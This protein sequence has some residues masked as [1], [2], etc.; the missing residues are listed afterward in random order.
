MA[1]VQAVPALD[2]FS[3][4]IKL[5]ENGS[6]VLNVSGELDLLTA[7]ALE[8]SLLGAVEDDDAHVTLDLTDVT[9]I[10]S[11]GLVML[12][13]LAQRSQEN[14]DWLRIRCGCA[15]PVRRVIEICG[16]EGRLPLLQP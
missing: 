12:L 5:R 13:S 3:V 16:A 14:G 7:A 9:F 11:S 10:D 6:L 8:G 15:A 4:G 1:T 2:L